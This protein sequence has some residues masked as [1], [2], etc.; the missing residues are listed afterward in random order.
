MLAAPLFIEFR[1]WSS[2]N[3]EALEFYIQ[4]R[5]CFEGRSLSRN[6]LKRNFLIEIEKAF[7][8]LKE[9]EEESCEME[10]GQGRNIF[11]RPPTHLSFQLEK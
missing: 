10:I 7:Q 2:R 5:W 11:L 3:W 9:E 6:L 1:N 8:G 4:S